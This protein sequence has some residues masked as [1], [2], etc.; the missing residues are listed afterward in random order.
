MLKNMVYKIRNKKTGEWFVGGSNP[1]WTPEAFS[2]FYK[3]PDHANLA[4][5]KLKKNKH[6]FLSFNEPWAVERVQEY[7]KFLDDAEVVAIVF[8]TV[9]I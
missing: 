2:A 5:N 7:D 9:Q 1:K 4:L 6:Y 3:S 8:R